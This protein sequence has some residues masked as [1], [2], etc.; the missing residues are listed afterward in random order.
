MNFDRKMDRRRACL[1]L[2]VVA[3]MVL[4]A[5]TGFGEGSGAP[6]CCAQTPHEII[7]S[8]HAVAIVR[9]I[10]GSALPALLLPDSNRSAFGMHSPG[11]L[12]PLADSHFRFGK[13]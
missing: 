12:F 13:Q 5:C 3:M 4:A 11:S 1:W 6:D 10:A 9:L 7:T 8:T 2:P